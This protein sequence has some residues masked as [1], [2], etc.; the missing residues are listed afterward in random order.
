M[1]GGGCK[2]HPPT[3][4]RRNVNRLA[5][6][7]PWFATVATNPVNPLEVNLRNDSPRA[8]QTSPGTLRRVSLQGFHL[9][10][11]YLH[12]DLHWYGVRTGFPLSVFCSFPYHAPFYMWGVLGRRAQ[13]ADARNVP[14]PP[15]PTDPK[16]PPPLERN[17]FSGLVHSAGKLLH[18]S[19]RIST[20]MTTARLS[21]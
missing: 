14:P 12:Q 7:F 16:Q 5:F 3:L 17:P 4:E 21:R 10:D 20:S 19:W 6:Q 8:Y 9:N 2:A 18:T 1:W 11:C 15:P 13:R